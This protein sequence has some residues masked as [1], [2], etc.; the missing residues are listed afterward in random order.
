MLSGSTWKQ[1]MRAYGSRLGLLFGVLPLFAILLKLLLVQLFRLFLGLL[2][3]RLLGLLF[4]VLLWVL[5]LIWLLS[6]NNKE[7]IFWLFV[8][9]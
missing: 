5:L 1:V 7:T 2:L 9:T 8:R 4:G 6:K 3:G